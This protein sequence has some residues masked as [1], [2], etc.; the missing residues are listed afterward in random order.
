M[1]QKYETPS[2]DGRPAV[3]SIEVG[4]GLGAGG[5]MLV[6]AIVGLPIAVASFLWLGMAVGFGFGDSGCPTQVN[7]FVSNYYML[8]HLLFLLSIPILLPALLRLREG[9]WVWTKRSLTSG[10]ILCIVG[11]ALIAYMDASMDRGCAQILEGTFF[12]AGGLA[13]G[14]AILVLTVRSASRL[15]RKLS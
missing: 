15:S 3:P 8:G 4:K 5:T 9:G 14:I 10:L 12:P 6:G 1:S 2:L 7:S 11:I 13:V